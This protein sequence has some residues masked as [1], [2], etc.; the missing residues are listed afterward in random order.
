MTVRRIRHLVAPTAA[1]ALLVL[2]GCS[3]STG[4]RTPSPSASPSP[5]RSGSAEATPCVQT[6]KLTA[7]LVP[8][9]DAQ[10]DTSLAAVAALSPDDVWAVGWT[11][12]QS[13]PGQAAAPTQTLA[14]NWNGTS[15][16]IV[17]VPDAG[18]A[19]AL[20]GDRLTAVAAVAPDDI[21]AVGYVG[22][23]FSYWQPFQSGETSTPEPQV[24]TLIEHWNGEAWSIV[25][26]PD[27]A[28][29]NGLSGWDE[30]TGVAAISAD[31]V[32]AVGVTLWP[33]NSNLDEPAAQPLIEHWNGTAWSLATPA[34]P[35]APP[36][37]WSMAANSF[38]GPSGAAAVGSAALM[39]VAATSSTDVWAVGGYETDMGLTSY[40]PSPWETLTEHWNGTSW[41]VVPAPDAT[42]PEPLT[43]GSTEP[44]DLL[45][46]AA[47]AP[48]GNVWAVGGAMPGSALTL[49]LGVGF[50]TASFAGWQLV[51]ILAVTTVESRGEA[52]VPASVTVSLTGGL[53]PLAGVVTL[54]ASDAWAVGAV[55][56]H[57]DGTS[58]QPQY[59]VNGQPF[60]YLTG[61]AAGSGSLWAVGGTSIVHA[62]CA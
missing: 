28:D 20:G 2:A 47:E 29:L 43:G 21:W 24:Q 3:S 7:A 11:G 10:A 62:T 55:I 52:P 53:S 13:Q 39:G 45:T 41:S 12:A 5:T 32:W 23:P 25:D 54:S 6:W 33:V 31:D 49:R 8:S 59:T 26:A 36:P 30:L 27:V 44:D 17:D 15:W 46:A 40:S 35:E 50:G 38:F 22:V 16:K 37:A 34:D 60:D 19:A 51:P 57:W 48:G 14:E 61:V 9:G 58:W 1:T 56:L 42:L 4:G 18:N